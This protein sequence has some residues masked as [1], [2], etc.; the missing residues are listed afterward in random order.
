MFVHFLV[1]F[2]AG[3]WPGLAWPGLVSR[4]LAMFFSRFVL[5]S[6]V[7]S[8]SR[9]RF[10]LGHFLHIV[11]LAPFSAYFQRIF[12]ALARAPQHP[13]TRLPPVRFRW[14]PIFPR[15]RRRLRHSKTKYFVLSSRTAQSRRRCCAREE[16][17]EGEKTE[18]QQKEKR[19]KK[20]RRLIQ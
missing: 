19:K 9:S 18:R 2:S 15:P 6:I 4:S 20:S 1:Y 14:G 11:C 16:R 12:S 10:V 13:P 17:E 7:L 5:D 3:V 8:K